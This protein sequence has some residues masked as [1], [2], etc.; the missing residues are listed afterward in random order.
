MIHGLAIGD[1][2]GSSVTE[3]MS[4]RRINPADWQDGK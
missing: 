1:A 4:L 2:L 3:F